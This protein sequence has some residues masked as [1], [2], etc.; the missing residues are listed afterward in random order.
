MPIQRIG[1]LPVTGA[2]RFGGLPLAG[3]ARVAGLG[4]LPGLLL[5]PSSIIPDPFVYW[6]F[7]DGYGLNG[8][9]VSSPGTTYPYQCEIVPN[10]YG[11]LPWAAGAL[12]GIYGGEAR[13]DEVGEQRSGPDVSGSIYSCATSFWLLE[14]LIEVEPGV[15]E[16][17]HISITGNPGVYES[18]S[19]GSAVARIPI[20]NQWHHYLTYLTADYRYTYRDGVLDAI[21]PGDVNILAGESF[22]YH[23]S[24]AGASICELCFW[25]GPSWDETERD[26]IAAALYN[27]GLGAVYRDG[28][29]WE[30]A[31]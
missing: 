9:P 22:G 11:K 10:E 8:G 20:E 5:A 12:G 30:V 7:E 28:Q 14:E 6:S 2:V 13:C 23:L 24:P 17:S 4:P 21:D 3:A 25:F 29:W 27:D 15:F 26:A 19:A 31:E 18:W 1:G 16:T